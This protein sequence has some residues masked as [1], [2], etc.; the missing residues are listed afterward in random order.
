MDHELGDLLCTVTGATPRGWRPTPAWPLLLYERAVVAIRNSL[1]AATWQATKSGA[2]WVDD[3]QRRRRTEASLPLAQLLGEHPD[4]RVVYP[5]DVR[6]ARLHNGVID[7]RVVLEMMDGDTVRWVWTPGDGWRAM[8]SP[9]GP[10]AEVEAALRAV[11]G[12]KLVTNA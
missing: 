5:D 1:V 12:D 7:A 9:N 6:S 2:V 8:A 10:I 3:Q 4:N 11:L